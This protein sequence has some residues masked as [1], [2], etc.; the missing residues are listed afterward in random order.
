MIVVIVVM[1]HAL[2]AD[3]GVASAPAMLNTA[4]E[5]AV[6]LAT[7]DHLVVVISDFDGT[8]DQTRRLMTLLA[9]HNDVLA[10]R[11]YDPARVEMPEA[12]QFV[13]SDGELQVEL[14]SGDLQRVSE[15]F[16]ER[17]REA[18]ETLRKL[19]V[20]LLA[21]STAE[22]VAPQVRKQLGTR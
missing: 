4:L 19:G 16:A 15:I 22:E 18:L 2:R 14:E 3:S 20:P 9:A 21:I 6:R 10:I 8:D 7:H 5:R 12:G 11:V 1:N 13:V 17:D